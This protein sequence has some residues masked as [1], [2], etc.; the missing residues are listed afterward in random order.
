MEQSKYF[1]CEEGRPQGGIISPILDNMASDGL[2]D[3]VIKGRNKKRQKLN[4][5]RYADDFVIT[6][7]TEEI[8]RDEILPAVKNFLHPRG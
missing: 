1:D 3:I 2:E 5:I 4:V 7:A 8:L 6:G